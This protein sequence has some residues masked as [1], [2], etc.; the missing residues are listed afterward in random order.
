MDLHCDS[1]LNGYSDC[2]HHQ[3]ASPFPSTTCQPIS[4]TDLSAYSRHRPASQ[5]NAPVGII[6]SLLRSNG[7]NDCHYSAD[8][9]NTGDSHERWQPEHQ[10]SLRD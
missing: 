1:N 5:T 3:P 6:L 10:S 8:L 7:T 4:L 9:I 2:A